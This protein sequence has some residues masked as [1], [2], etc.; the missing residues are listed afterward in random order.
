MVEVVRHVR[1]ADA[2]VQKVKD[3]AVG[4]VDG[5][6]RALLPRPLILPEVRHVFRRVLQP[7]VQ[8]QPSV[9]HLPPPLGP[10]PPRQAQTLSPQPV[11]NGE[12]TRG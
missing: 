11:A 4:A 7:R 10:N 1:G 3:R 12:G 6:E 2:V 8:H 5:H 9:G